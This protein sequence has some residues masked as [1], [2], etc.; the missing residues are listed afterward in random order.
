MKKINDPEWSEAVAKT[1]IEIIKDFDEEYGLKVLDGIDKIFEWK[2]DELNHT[3][4]EFIE[5][6]ENKEDL[7][8]VAYFLLGLIK[9]ANK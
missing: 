1:V 9:D 8:K 4:K 7:E 6:Y 2:D 3:E 5:M